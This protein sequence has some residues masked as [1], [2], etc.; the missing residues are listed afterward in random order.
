FQ[1]VAVLRSLGRAQEATQLVGQLRK[2]QGEESLNGQLA[3]EGTKA[4]DLLQSG[5]PT[6]AAQIYRHM[7]EEDPDS[8]QTAYNLVLALEAMND[9]KGAKDALHKAIDRNPT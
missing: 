5:K 8:A 6:E 3:S 9:T 4:N 2:E 7:L 1:L